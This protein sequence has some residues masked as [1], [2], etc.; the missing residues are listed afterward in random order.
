MNDGRSAILTYHSLDDSGSVISTPPSQFQRQMEFLAASGIPVVPLNQ[1]LDRPGSVAITFDDGF[2]NILDHAVPAL[3]RQRFPATVFV[4][5]DYCGRRNNWPSQ[6]AGIPSLP[7]MSWEELAGLPALMSVGAHT[8]THPNLM[9]LSASECEQEMSECQTRIEQ[10]LGRPV[11]WLAYPYGASSSKVRALASQH[12]DLAVGTSLRFLPTEYDPLDLP[13]IDTYY[14]RGWLSL[15]RLFT[16]SGRLYLGTR[17]LLREVR[18][19]VR[20]WYSPRRK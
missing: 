16:R 7:L 12:F 5:S 15:E 8:A 20:P 1:A 3:E 10:S 6:S 14:L 4:V 18:G 17:A 2:R 13:R 9:R 11:R 19:S